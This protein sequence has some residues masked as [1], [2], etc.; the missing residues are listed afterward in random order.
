MRRLRCNKGS[1]RQRR[2]EV[3][4]PGTPQRCG[5]LSQRRTPR[6]CAAARCCS[7][8]CCRGATG[9]LHSLDAAAAMHRA[10]CW[11][12][13]D[14]L[15]VQVLPAAAPVPCASTRRHERPPCAAREGLA[16]STAR[17]MVSTLHAAAA[18]LP[19]PVRAPV[20]PLGVVADLVVGAEPNPVPAFRATLMRRWRAVS[21][22]R[23]KTPH[24]LAARRVYCEPGRCSPHVHSRDGA[25]LPGLLGQHLL[26]PAA[27]HAVVEGA[28][29]CPRARS[30]HE[31]ASIRSKSS[32]EGLVGRHLVPAR[33]EGEGE[34]G[35]GRS[36]GKHRKPL[37]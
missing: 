10:S 20:A 17:L 36:H 2:A 15:P 19:P 27:S 1:R 21:A 35:P 4:A 13:W 29:S 31:Q 25:V 28:R 5:H 37:G 11:S 3:R 34:P 6:P 26:D 8:W 32:P 16:H 22:G 14:V 18:P 33:L 7:T 23:A 30:S 9:H 24:S 12:C